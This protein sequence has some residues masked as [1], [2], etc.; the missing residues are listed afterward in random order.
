MPGTGGNL[1]SLLYGDRLSFKD[2]Q[3]D[4]EL[5]AVMVPQNSECTKCQWIVQLKLV[6]F[7]LYGFYF[8]NKSKKRKKGG[9]SSLIWK[10]NITS[11]NSPESKN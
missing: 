9:K 10:L 2:D 3:N 8:N 5:E 6:G 11:L 4:L 1:E 7:M